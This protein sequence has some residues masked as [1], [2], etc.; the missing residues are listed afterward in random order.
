MLAAAT[1]AAHAQ[2]LTLPQY[3]GQ[4]FDQPFHVAGP[5]GDPSRLLVAEAPGRIRLVKDGVTRPDPFLDIAADV[6][7][8]TGAEGSCECGLFSMAF[9]PDYASSGILYVF[10]TRDSPVAGEAHYLRIEEFRRSAADP[11]RA[12]PAT[13]RVV[14]EIPHLTAT[15]HNGGQLQFGPDGLLYISVG[16]GGDTPLAAQA[17][18]TRLGKILRI[19]PRGAAPGEYSIP[20]GNPFADGP[21]G[22]AD[23]IY[24][25]G[26]RNPYRFSFDR[27]TGDLVI[28]DVGGGSW[29]EVDYVPEGGGKGANF[30]WPCF[31][32]AHVLETSGSC[33]PP[34]AGHVAPVHEYA[35]PPA[36]AA[37]VSGGYVVRDPSLP[38]LLGRY[39]YAD[40]YGA[41]P[42]IRALSL[43]PAGAS[44]DTDLGVSAST[45]VSFGQDACGHV[46]VAA[47][48]GGGVV[49]RLEPQGAALACKTAPVLRLDAGAAARAA[50]RGVVTVAVSC[51]EDCSAVA[52]ARIRVKRSR[53]ARPFAIGL[54]PVTARVQLEARATLGLVLPKRAVK[55][56]RRALKAKRRAVAEI[57]VSA[58]G[59]GGGT[60]LA[61]AR[62][63]LRR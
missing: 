25:Y 40:T 13:R 11:D 5:P 19:D 59:A 42:G 39:V 30:G 36:E 57:E 52:S 48:G 38:S 53:K 7:D 34:L 29:E 41:V 45:P 43:A 31:E 15:N 35:N 56:L 28:G 60:A 50:K 14:M 51:D 32:G 1:T 18:D 9:A 58:G 16:D 62:V 22:N 2:T 17:L 4:G 6:W 61:S 3:G 27:A 47:L 49:S 26:L 63:R 20:P 24:S 33:S 10:Y 55:R 44:G 12:D 23:E 37:A 46:Y 8:N 21:G 54:A